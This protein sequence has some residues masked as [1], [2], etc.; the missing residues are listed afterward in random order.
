MTIVRVLCIGIA[1]C[2]AARPLRH[3]RPP[4]AAA[5]A[6][7]AALAG[8]RGR[9]EP[10]G[11]TERRLVRGGRA[12]VE[13]RRYGSSL[14]AL[15]TV[16]AGVRQHHPPSVCLRA[17]GYEI[18][19]RR[20]RRRADRCV[21]E[22]T[23]RERASGRSLTFFYAYGDGRHQLCSLWRRIGI[24]AMQQLF[25]EHRSWWTAQLLDPDPARARRRF[26]ALLV[27]LDNLPSQEAHR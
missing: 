19:R 5:R 23:V 18:T 21:V 22:L 4:A 24:A 27:A 10:L 8:V 14:A 17:S 1:A 26:A 7:P 16:T 15:V 11:D 9:R 25:G 12:L 6:L 13:R 3:A 2:C 20:E